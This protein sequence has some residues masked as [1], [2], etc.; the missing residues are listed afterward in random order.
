MDIQ[1]FL[2]FQYGKLENMLV[3]YKH[4]GTLDDSEYIIIPNYNYDVKTNDN[5][6]FIIINT[7]LYIIINWPFKFKIFKIHKC[8][9]Y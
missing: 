6:N 2:Y 4:E 7:L 1:L 9:M 8:L 5:I 3:H